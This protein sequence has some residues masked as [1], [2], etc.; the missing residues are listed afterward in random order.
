MSIDFDPPIRFATGLSLFLQAKSRW[1]QFNDWLRPK[2][3][4]DFVPPGLLLR[5]S[6]WPCARGLEAQWLGRCIDSML[7]SM[8]PDQCIEEKVVALISLLIAE[9]IKYLVSLLMSLSVH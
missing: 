9:S 5:M 7:S 6:R 8:Q 1:I 4:P 3:I 2:N